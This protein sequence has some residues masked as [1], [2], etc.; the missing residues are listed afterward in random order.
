M[1]KKKGTNVYEKKVT[2][3]RAPDGKPIRKSVTGRTIVELNQKIEDMKQKWMEMNDVSEGILFST[4]AKRWLSSS[5]AVRSL[6]TQRMYRETLNKILPQ[7]GD[8]YFSEISLSDLQGIIN[9]KADK[10]E[11]C[12]KIRLT[13][14]QIYDA[15]TEEG[16]VKG[17]NTKKLV[18]PQKPSKEKRALSDSETDAIFTA[19]LT[20]EQRVFVKVLYYTGV[21]REEALALEPSDIDFKDNV[22]SVSKVVIFPQ[23]QPI[24]KPNPKSSAG[25]RKVPIPSEF[26]DELKEYVSRCDKYL[27]PRTDDPS[28]YMSKACYSKFWHYILTAMEKVE[29]SSKTL[30]AHIFR[31]NYA[32]LLY[33]SNVS[34]KKA[35]KLMGHNGIQMIMQIYAHLDEQKENTAEKIDGIFKRETPQPKPECS[36]KK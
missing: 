16:L 11:T 9:D 14:R 12:N 8:Y 22:L 18:L 17:I 21:R 29:P 23:N 3:G 5:K 25:N 34:I 36:P 15:A 26:K 33:Y 7:I 13:L 10:Y 2:L 31:H 35:A 30:T 4:Y 27:F 6:N 24:L 28:K 1:K 19:D 20:D 32:T